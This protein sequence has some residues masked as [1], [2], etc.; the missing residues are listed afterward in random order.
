MLIFGITNFTYLAF[1][2]TYVYK[3]LYSGTINYNII[4]PS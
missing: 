4:L 1:Y 3:N 2:S